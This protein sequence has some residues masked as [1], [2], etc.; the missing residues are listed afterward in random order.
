MA[1]GTWAQ[2]QG[3][4]NRRKREADELDARVIG[5]LKPATTGFP[6][7]PEQTKV[8]GIVI[9]MNEIKPAPKFTRE[10]IQQLYAPFPLEAHDIR[11]GYRTSNGKIRWFVYLSRNAIQRRLDE[12]FPGE[13]EFVPGERHQTDTHVTYSATLIIRGMKRGFNGASDPATRWDGPKGNKEQVT[14]FNADV[15]KGAMTD[16]FRR[17]AS[18]WGLG[19]YL[20]DSVMIHTAGYE[21]GQWDDQRAREVDAKKQFANWYNGLP[22]G[23]SAA[24]TPAENTPTPPQTPEPEAQ[25]P[26]SRQDTSNAAKTPEWFTPLVTIMKK[27]PHF[28]DGKKGAAITKHVIHALNAMLES[29][30][31]SSDMSQAAALEMATAKYNSPIQVEDDVQF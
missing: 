11:E 6:P 20:Y 24:E 17:V 7:E 30:E 23:K 22:Q 27:W 28:A 25:Q 26:K 4:V 29:G 9:P 1:N 2:K 19:D 16:T 5:N 15:E 8:K 10:E 3:Q 18:L 14:V 13:W 21:R 12:L 31:L